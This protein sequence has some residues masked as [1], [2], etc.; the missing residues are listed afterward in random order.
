MSDLMSQLEKILMAHTFLNQVD[1]LLA[2]ACASLAKDPHLAVTAI[3]QTWLQWFKTTGSGYKGEEWVH[4][5]DVHFA[6][7]DPSLEFLMDNLMAGMMVSAPAIASASDTAKVYQLFEDLSPNDQF[8]FQHPVGVLAVARGEGQSKGCE[9]KEA[10]NCGDIQ[11]AGPSTPKAVAGGVARGLAMLPRLATTLRSK[12]KGKGKAWEEEDKDI[13]DQI[14][15]TFTNKCLATLLHWQKASTVVDTGLG[16]GVKLEKAKGKVMVPLE[17]RQEYKHTQGARNNCWADND[18]EGCCG[19][20]LRSTGGKFAKKIATKAAL[21]RNTRAFME[22]QRELSQEEAVIGGGGGAKVKSREMVESDEDGSDN[23]SDGDVPLAQ[24]QAASSVLVTSTKRPRTVASEEGEGD[25]EMGETTPLA[26]VAEVE[27]EAS[28]MEI[29]GKEELEVIPVA[30]EEEER[31]E[32][33]KGTWSD[34][35]LCQVGDNELEWLGKDLSWLTPLTSAALLVDFDERVAGVEWQ[36]QRELETAREELLAV[37]AHYTV[38]KQMLQEENNV[39]EVDWE[40]AEAM[41]VP[42]DDADL[43]T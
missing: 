37:W 5:F 43:N 7:V 16:A 9:G 12:G 2:V 4:P 17:R 13:E 31:G 11:E 25:M 23:D 40:E 10:A 36:F 19:R 34:M 26:T 42:D 28:N 32:E 18:P 35:P 33:V 39:R 24:K 1:R 15:E 27:R 6:P 3:F 8:F 22:Q 14:E 21:V 29:E 20:L 41:E 30:A 38:A